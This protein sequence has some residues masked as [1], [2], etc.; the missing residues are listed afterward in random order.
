MAAVPEL[1]ATAWGRADLDANET[2]SS[3]TA[4]PLVQVRVPDAMTRCSSA[5]SE[6]ARSRPLASRSLGNCKDDKEGDERGKEPHQWGRL[7]SPRLADRVR[8]GAW[9]PYETLQREETSTFPVRCTQG[10]RSRVASLRLHSAR[11]RLHSPAWAPQAP[12]PGKT[13][14]VERRQAQ[15]THV[16]GSLPAR[17]DESAA[18]PPSSATL[19]R[20]I[21]PVMLSQHRTPGQA[22]QRDA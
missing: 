21:V 8:R 4:R 19:T 1:H 16:N 3:R 20:R 15:A 17:A 14:G 7:A 5:I 12:C 9:Q 6:A 18:F 11:R 10:P 13:V 22:G 2:S